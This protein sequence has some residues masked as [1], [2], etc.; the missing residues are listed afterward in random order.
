[1]VRKL[2]WANRPKRKSNMNCTHKYIHTE[3]MDEINLFFQCVYLD[4]TKYNQTSC[5]LPTKS[6]WAAKLI[7]CDVLKQILSV[8][9]L[10]FIWS[11]T[12]CV[13]LTKSRIRKRFQ[14]SIYFFSF[15]YIFLGFALSLI[16]FFLCW[17]KF[18]SRLIEFQFSKRAT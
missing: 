18:N 10:C 6:Y 8:A 9:Y 5:A 15:F 16:R 12:N 14:F 11:Q 4:I 13:L 2:K 7:W 3:K 17:P 1:M